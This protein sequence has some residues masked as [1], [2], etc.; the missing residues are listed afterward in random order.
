M[1]LSFL[2]RGRG[3]PTVQMQAPAGS[4]MGNSSQRQF[5]QPGGLLGDSIG[6]A[7]IS[8]QGRASLTLLAGLIVLSIV[9]YM[10][11]RDAQGS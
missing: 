1:A 7:M 8:F 9:F 2:D 3:V 6:D 5:P 11:T 10:A 4:D